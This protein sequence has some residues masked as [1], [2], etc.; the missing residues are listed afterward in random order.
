[1]QKSD[2]MNY[3]PRGKARP[4]CGPGEFRFAAVGLDHGHI[5]GMCNGLIEAGGELASVFDPDPQKI[6]AFR[7]TYGGVKVARSEAEVLE[8]PPIRLIASAAIPCRRGPLGLR[9]MD[10]GKD[11][12]ADKPPLTSAA[13]LDAARAKAAETGRIYAAYYSERLHVEAAVKAGELIQQGAIGRVL[14]VIGLG[15]HRLNAPT[16]PAWFWDPE[17]AGGILL[18]I[19][20]HQIEQFLYFAGAA[21]ARVLHSK[22]A[23]YRNPDHPAF[24]D[25]GDA[26]LVAD[27]GATAYFRVDWF[28]PAGLGAWGDGRTLILGTD[29]YIELRKY[30]DVAR[31]AAGDHLYLVDHKGEHHLAVHGTVG[32]PYFGQLILD[33]LNRTEHAMPQRHT[34]LAIEL[35]LAAQARAITVT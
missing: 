15:P 22:L 4:V 2:G 26:T 27:N 1:M 30:L 12:F 5:Y 35:A 28:T 24:Q 8:D 6:E 17:Q 13:Q 11:Y 23:N 29:G 32:F 19:G 16:R 10:H 9:V 18:D 31:D 14:Q 34:F 20:C 3:A 25:F 33:C 21:G 7:G